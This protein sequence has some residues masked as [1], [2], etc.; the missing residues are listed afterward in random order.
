MVLDRAEALGLI[1]PAD[2]LSIGGREIVLVQGR[3]EIG[4]VRDLARDEVGE[5]LR[6][7]FGAIVLSALDQEVRVRDGFGGELS[8]GLQT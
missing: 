1:L 2:P 7:P 5:Q 3:D 8:I 6:P 4:A